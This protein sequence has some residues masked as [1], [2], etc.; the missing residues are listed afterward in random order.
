MVRAFLTLEPMDGTPQRV[1]IGSSIVLGRA[2]DC[3]IVLDD[4]AASRRH[5]EV[6]AADGAFHWRDLGSTNGTLVNGLRMLEGVLNDGDELRIGETLLIFELEQI[7]DEESEQAEE[8]TL[9]KETL[10]DWDSAPAADSMEGKSEG[11]LRAVYAVINEIA[12]N[13]EPCSLVDRILETTVRAI[14]AQR[15]AIFFTSEK[16]G[17]VDPCPVCGR[18]HVI[19][20]GDLR[21]VERDAIRI[22]STVASRV[23]TR[24]ES[25]L[26]QDSEGDEDLDIADSIMSLSLRSIICVPLRGKSGILGILYIDTNRQGHKYTHEHMLLSTA[27]GN[28]AGL[29][30]ENATMHLE[31]LEKQ[32]MEQ[33]IQHAWTIQEGFLVKEWPEGEPCFEV[34]GKTKP[35][36]TVG[37]DFYDFIRPLPGRVGILIGDV[38]GKG[39]PAALT[40][41]QLLAEFRLCARGDRP[42]SEVIKALNEDLCA[43]S[44]RGIFCTMC[45][46]TLDLE[47]GKVLCCN[48][49]HHPALRIRAT[50]ADTFGGATGPPAGIVP[51]GPWADDGLD[52][53]AGESVLL[54]TDGIVEA[55]KHGVVEVVEG[56]L[57]EFGMGA[58][59][60]VA[61]EEHASAPRALLERINAEID[62]YCSPGIPHDDCTMIALRYL[63]GAEC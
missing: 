19:E 41:A 47:T 54:Y 44:Q 51:T 13:Y 3:G 15:G 38:S 2:M 61:A 25:V 48:A 55:R 4:E 56:G 11:L 53:G 16:R 31:M 49:G 6:F 21:H 24:G 34:Y 30:L 7:P 59:C 1:P 35:A 57:R 36:K 8:T 29:A 17:A 14:D 23:L 62:A 22:S 26:Y 63:A 10:A 37:G 40:M 9:F 20:E 18:F 46:I 39:V 5:I 32:R 42:P 28:S 43:R 52:L 27:V 60:R 58:L 33:E 12:S 50:G 45:Y